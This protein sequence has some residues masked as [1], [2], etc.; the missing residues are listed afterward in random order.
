MIVRQMVTRDWL[1]VKDATS[2]AKYSLIMTCTAAAWLSE[3]GGFAACPACHMATLITL[4]LSAARLDADWPSPEHPQQVI[5]ACV[6]SADA[7]E[8]PVLRR[9]NAIFDTGTEGCLPCRA[10]AYA[11]GYVV[12]CL[13]H[14]YVVLAIKMFQ[15][16]TADNAVLIG[17][18]S[19]QLAMELTPTWFGSLQLWWLLRCAMSIWVWHRLL[20]PTTQP[21]L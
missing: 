6:F 8:E 14:E 10:R 9:D 11:C 15:R 13:R 12:Q 17:R 7:I 2:A 3:G 1:V 21:Q 16:T 5:G 19:G 4:Q 18:G 20:Q